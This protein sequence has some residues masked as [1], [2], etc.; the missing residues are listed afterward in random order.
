MSGR[1][2]APEYK[3]RMVELVRAGRSADQLAREFE[4]SATAIRL[5]SP[6]GTR[7]NRN[8]RQGGA[9]MPLSRNKSQDAVQLRRVG[10]RKRIRGLA[11]AAVVWAAACGDADPDVTG[12]TPLQN[13]APQAVGAIP[14][15]TVSVGDTA[16]VD[17]STYFSDPDGDALAYTASSSNAE[18]AGVSVSGGSVVVAALA[19]GVVTVTVTARDPQGLVAQQRFR[20]T[21]P[22]RGPV[23]AGAIPE[24]TVSVGDTAAVD[25]S[26]YFS[27]P[28]GDALAY[29]ASSS[30]A[31]VAGVSVSGGSVVVAALAR[32]VVTVTVTARDP[33]GLVAQ[34]R[35]RVT[36]PNRGPVAAGAIPE[37]TVSVGDTAAVD[38]STYFSDPDGDALA[39]TASSSNAEVA[40]VS[41]SGGSVV[42]A[43]L[44]RGVVTVTVTARDP[45][46]LV[47]QQRFRV[48]VP[49]RGPVAAGA[50]PEHTVSVGDTAAVDASTYF[51]DPDGDALA[52][53][54]SSSNAEVAGVSVSG[55][56]VVVAALARGV[57][58][59]TVTARDPGSLSVSSSFGVTVTGSAPGFQIQLVFT[60]SVTERQELVFRGAAERWMTILASTELPDVSLNRTVNCGPQSDRVGTIDDLM[61]MAAVRRIDGPG[62]TLAFAYVCYLRNS[63]YLPA[64][65]GM[66]F[67]ADDLR[68]LDQGGILEDVILHEIG[69]V[70]G[71]GIIWDDLGLLRNP[72]SETEAPDTHFAGPL[73]IEA[74][75]HAGGTG[76]ED[77]KVPVENTGGPGSR[78]GHWRETVLVTELMTPRVG[79]GGSNPLSAITIQSLADIGYAVDPTVADSYRLPGA[80]AAREIEPARLIPFGDDIWRGP[81][82]VVDRDGRIVRVNPGPDSSDRRRD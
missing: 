50:I 82:V 77:A 47:A 53:T 72:A 66:V 28:D 36:V 75:D 37:H 73:A 8:E 23:A 62:G 44:A 59:V 33:Q 34:Q 40:G 74:F 14:E 55:G 41:V 19:R 79:R 24:H 68:R 18:V 29:T 61:I 12:P 3:A 7:G 65:G 42:V 51:S 21:V 57:V 10:S 32:G 48:T 5:D 71:I 30:N 43:A 46:G 78:N 63:P 67:D 76:Y 20:V 70:L 9:L 80:D 54:A 15:H 45:Q 2:Y 81:I 27:D 25:A 56:S 4:P 17:A 6:A 13:R 11:A 49:N 64:I 60:T 52:Y 26:T 1:R 69:H 22:N 31:E 39:Y 16:A 35:F 58:T 38:A